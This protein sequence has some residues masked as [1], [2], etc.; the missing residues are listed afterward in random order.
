MITRR[1]R[2]ELDRTLFY[3]AGILS[4]FLAI[5]GSGFAQETAAPPVDQ[6]NANANVNASPSLTPAPTPVPISDIVP[7]T[8]RVAASLRQIAAGTG[9]AP[10]LTLVERELPGTINTIDAR[11]AE[12]ARV[13]E[14]RPSLER[15]QSLETE[16]RSV[17][18]Q[19]EGWNSD[20]T[21]RAR[22]FEIDL[23]RLSEL[24]RK[25]KQTLDELQAAAA[26]PEVSARVTEIL[27]MISQTRGEIEAERARIIAMQSRIA[28]QES[29]VDDVVRSIQLTR[30]TLVGR[31]LVQDSPPMWSSGFWARAREESANESILVQWTAL[32]DFADQ[33]TV[34]LV[35]HFL[36]FLGL[37]G[38][39][40]FLRRF[41]RPW[42]EKEPALRKAAIIFSFPLST[43]AILAIFLNNW[44]YMRTPQLL[45]AIFG[46]VALVPTVIIVRK[47]VERPIYPI[48]YSLVVFYFIDQVRMVGEAL[49]V[50]SRLV[51][52][53]EM[54]AGMAFF[55]WLIFGR[56]AKG[57]G[58]GETRGR[59]FKTIRLAATVAVPVFAIS[60]IANVLGYVTL[61]QF[62][63][64]AALRSAYAAIILYAVIRIVDGLIIF[65]LRFRPL[66][67]L[68]MV[69][70][71]HI[72]IQNRVQRVTRWLG[73]I[74]WGLVVLDVL[75]V[76]TTLFTAVSDILTAELK[77]GS[78]AVSLSDIAAFAIAVWASFLL[79][80]FVRFVLEEDVYPRVSIA[81]GL[82]YAISTVLHYALIVAGF[83]LALAVIGLDLTKFTIIAG[84][85]GVGIGFGLQNI[86]NNFVSGIILLFERPV[87]V[88][89]TIQ[90]DEDSGDLTRIGLRASVIRTLD[91]SE[92][93]VPN[94]DLISQKVVNWTLSDQR[95]RLEIE[96]G[97]AYGTD[98]RSVIGILAKVG[99]DNPQV[100][101]DPAPTALFLGF[102]DS[103][104]NFQLRAWTDKFNEWVAIKS[105]L[106]M[107]VYD[108]FNEANIEIPFPQRDIHLIRAD[109][110]V[111]SDGGNGS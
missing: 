82:P 95:R 40:A 87:N 7:Q 65:A 101:E 85:F 77:I 98:P 53:A 36:I 46:A 56:L 89:D 107:S 64:N 49:P 18:R 32:K 69:R 51:L 43:A 6:A 5:P 52:L 20:L 48:L 37:A 75:A 33:N 100:L 108:A 47:L 35:F 22:K 76:R 97:V 14:G 81:R 83:L 27:T 94:G 78:L 73:A 12:T 62:V 109:K 84:A 30:E 104:L 24:D 99:A 59:V 42:V 80:R 50:I 110:E 10:T 3:A 54:L 13:V 45:L 9:D 39:L 23:D 72:L 60:A 70:N 106:T 63:G 57:S 91:G 58:T 25:W 67:L 79:S 96:V 93:I 17:R 28:E 88:G 102:G 55:S 92:V 21:A 2:R 26:P 4:L 19:L 38:I 16:W 61:A 105:D 66:S 29:R 74:V 41:A 11:I 8:E 31:L 103:A 111:P 71:Q 34:R 1:T 68:G 90:V 15:L 86:V 44:M